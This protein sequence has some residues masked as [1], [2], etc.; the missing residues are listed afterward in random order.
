MMWTGHISLSTGSTDGNLS[1]GQHSLVFDRT[2]T[3]RPTQSQ[4]HCE[5]GLC[6]VE[7]TVTRAIEKNISS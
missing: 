5:A 7:L 4:S 1:I 2:G 3:A 6:S